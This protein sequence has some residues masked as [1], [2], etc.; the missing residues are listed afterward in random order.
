LDNNPGTV[1]YLYSNRF[2]ITGGGSPSIR[3]PFKDKCGFKR[4]SIYDNNDH[5]IP[6]PGSQNNSLSNTNPVNT[7]NNTANNSANNTTNTQSNASENTN[8]FNEEINNTNAD[9][10]LNPD[11]EITDTDIK[12]SKKESHSKPFLYF[13]IGVL[14][15]ALLVGLLYAYRKKKEEEEVYKEEEFEDAFNVDDAFKVEEPFNYG[16]A[17]NYGYPTATTTNNDTNNNNNNQNK[18]KSLHYSL[19]K[20]PSNRTSLAMHS[21]FGYNTEPMHH[22]HHNT[23]TPH[24]TLY[25]DNTSPR[26]SIVP[27]DN[28]FASSVGTNN[29]SSTPMAVSV[30]EPIET[31][32]TE[33]KFVATTSYEPKNEN[34]IA[35]SSLD[36]VYLVGY[37]DDK[38]AQIL[39]ITTNNYGIIPISELE[40]IQH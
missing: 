22:H 29:G 33:I 4:T 10:N 27:S 11:Q 17:Y 30:L 38:Y 40:K 31:P 36:I 21:D 1:N 5:S 2:E 13:I 20:I 7:A 26:S 3:P 32:S 37:I 19:Q 25:E 39:N 24:S 35:I 23:I 9:N 28:L 16:N 14:F 8:L 34:E 18:N 15:C 12:N 6:D